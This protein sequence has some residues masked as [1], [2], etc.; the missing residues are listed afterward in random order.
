MSFTKFRRALGVAALA[1]SSLVA[2]ICPPGAN[3][4]L[5]FDGID[6]GL[7][8]AAPAA[9]ALD[10]FANFTIECWFRADAVGN[11][12]QP[13]LVNKLGGAAFSYWLGLN[14]GRFFL[15]LNGV[16]VANLV[17]MPDVRDG[18]WHHAAVS[19][20]GS[21]VDILLDGA[22]L[23]TAAFAPVLQSNTA[24]FAAGKRADAAF[25]QYL[26][27]GL[28]EIRV[29][30]YARST[31]QIQAAR[32]T[33]VAGSEPGLRGYWRLDEASGQT[34][35]DLSV[36]AAHAVLGATIAAGADDPTWSTNT[37]PIPYCG[38][39]G[40][41]NANSA[42]ASLKINGV[43][44]LGVAGPFTATPSPTG[45]LT[46]EWSGPA[47]QPLILAT[48]PLSPGGGFIP[49][50]G[51]IDIGTPGSWADVVFLVNGVLPP[52]S[53]LF[54]TNGAGSAVQTFTVPPTPGAAF[55]VQGVVGQP[56]GPSAPFG[57]FLTATFYIVL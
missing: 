6:D 2:Q 27:G 1:A 49:G 34:A 7:V 31:A 42:A 25:S 28:D 22:L 55:A 37:S 8:V 48:G 3:G 19:R 30:N 53:Y 35:A 24:P 15:W 12:G 54:T 11:G 39:S 4:A 26:K 13:T 18:L 50:F 40:A 45:T 38:G 17:G 10:G 32:F 9:G 20:S 56:P 29:W 36:S 43:G 47:F 46:F 52:L 33:A 51:T 41:G 57:S 23:A 16:N 5:T 21:N 14:N 44:A